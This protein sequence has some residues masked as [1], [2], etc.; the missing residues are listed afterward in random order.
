[1]T[2]CSNFEFTIGEKLLF[3]PYCKNELSE[4]DLQHSLCPYCNPHIRDKEAIHLLE[5]GIMVNPPSVKDLES[6]GD[7]GGEEK[8]LEENESRETE[9]NTT[10]KGFFPGFRVKGEIGRGGFGSVLL[11]HDT[12]A[13]RDVAIKTFSSEGERRSRSNA[14]ERFLDEAYI[15]AQLQHPGIIPIYVIEKDAEGRY[16]YTMRPVEGASLHSIIQKLKKG[17]SFYIQNYPLRRLMQIMVSVC[18]TIR[19]AHERGVIHRDLKPGNIIVG[20]YGETLVIDWG[21]AKVIGTP[22]RAVDMVIPGEM[23]PFKSVWS[24]YERKI[25]SLRTGP[26]SSFMHT[27][28]GQ[29]MGTPAYMSPEQVRGKVEI[30]DFQTDI[31]SLGVILYE[32]A[33]LRLPFTGKDLDMLL[34]RILRATPTEAIDANPHQRVPPELSSLIMR[35]LKKEKHSRISRVEEIV[36]GLELWLEGIAPWELIYDFDFQSFPDGPF[37]ELSGSGGAWYVKNG[38]LHGVEHGNLLTTR[39]IPGDARI[40]VEASLE[41][42]DTC[43]IAPQL[44]APGPG[45]QFSYK[46]Y[47]TC[48]FA[49][50]NRLI[51]FYKDGHEVL[52]QGAASEERN[53]QI[54]AAEKVGTLISVSLNDIEQFRY[55]DYFPPDGLRHGIFCQGS[56]VRVSRFRILKRGSGIKVSCLD[57]PRAFVERGLLHEGTQLYGQ[58]VADHRGREEGYEAL[59]QLGLCKLEQAKLLDRARE[60]KQFKELVHEMFDIFRR[61]ERSYFAPLGVLGSSLVYELEGNIE[62]EVDE[63]LRAL[64]DY[65]DYSTIPHIIERIRYR[66]F[67]YPQTGEA[68]PALQQGIEKVLLSREYFDTQS[69]P[70]GKLPV[71]GL[72]LSEKIVNISGLRG[73]SFEWLDL[74]RTSVEDLRPLSETSLQSLSLP[75]SVSDIG[76]L[77]DI[78]LHTLDLSRTQVVDLSPLSKMPLKVLVLP[79]TVTT[80]EVL[81]DLPL[82]H[83]D[84]SRTQ[85]DDLAPLDGMPLHL[86]LLPEHVRQLKG[87]KNSGLNF[88]KI[89]TGTTD[90]RSLAGMKLRGLDLSLSDISDLSPLEGMDLQ[91]I[92]L[93]DKVS[94]LSALQNMPLES[95]DLYRTEVSDLRFLKRLPQLKRLNICPEKLEP[96]WDSILRELPALSVLGTDEWFI[97]NS[98]K[99][100]LK[101]YSSAKKKDGIGLPSA[102]MSTTLFQVNT[103]GAKFRW[104]PPGVF[105]MGS[106]INETGRRSDETQHFVALRAGFYMAVTP[107]TVG[108]FSR[109]VSLTGYK[110][111]AERDGGAIG[112]F[113]SQWGRI[114]GLSWHSPGF[115]QNDNFPVVCVSWDDARVFCAWLSDCEG[116][117]YRLATEAEWEYACRAGTGES[118][119][120]QLQ[121]MAWYDDNSQESSHEVSQ[122]SKN[123]WGLYDFHG[124]VWEWCLDNYDIYPT[125]F[126]IDQKGP[127]QSASRVIR[128]G[129]WSSSSSNCRSACRFS[130][131]PGYCV[132]D[133]GF[134]IVRQDVL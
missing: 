112:L 90:I 1:M 48:Y 127:E 120:G 30:I 21:L 85:I 24:R 101:K 47:L 76:P 31:W 51:R 110:T 102:S 128:G 66:L 58:I 52:T 130:S 93:S 43:F 129:G 84:L 103:L 42:V 133:L 115:Q 126:S 34:S 131:P 75:P 18:Q 54:I 95:L 20:D 45:E 2:L 74:S 11:A 41:D 56:G 67:I 27:L 83:L 38:L 91:F 22:E 77:R 26:E 57:V 49:G 3:C 124:N 16:F 118:F 50:K 12:G 104:I 132:S 114:A 55:R 59:F 92:V 10:E 88:I 106:P 35:C 121:N 71:R 39:D 60:Q 40:E 19:F 99:D 6:T 17:D 4:E 15:T 117:T 79:D 62:R 13:K 105:L 111:T 9:D 5:T 94:D 63:L 113:G 25:T 14:K 108:E 65:P 96:G 125:G 29:V 69:R 28:E 100:V 36:R 8:Q 109:F 46:G 23:E 73:T 134:R 80:I 72:Q 87:L 61:V 53:F 70:L 82:E 107:V 123:P 7:I 86:I 89:P 33:T 78:S 122:K 64:S 81:S 32:C 37:E 98:P 97:P 119:A 44:S 116:K 68:V